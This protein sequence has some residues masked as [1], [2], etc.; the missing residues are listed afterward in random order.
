MYPNISYKTLSSYAGTIK[1]NPRE[2]ANAALSVSLKEVQST[3]A[4][5]QKFSKG[6][7][8]RPREAGAIRDCVETIK[9]SVDDLQQSLAAIKDLKGP[10]FEWK[11]SDI[12]TWVSAAL[13]NEDTCMDNFEGNGMNVKIKDTV[14][15]CIVRVSQL[16]SN[17][18]AFI[19]KLKY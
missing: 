15:G 17:A 18:L 3:S 13:T 1:T 4:L 7:D 6:R 12:L 19:N 11:M 16:T 9:D 5:V 14:R 8:L 10:E 2:L